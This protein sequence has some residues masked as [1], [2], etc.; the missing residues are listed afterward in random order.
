M[1]LRKNNFSSPLGLAQADVIFNIFICFVL[2]TA[3][4]VV[5]SK[6]KKEEKKDQEKITAKTRSLIDMQLIATL[7]F[8]IKWPNGP[9][10]ID[11]WVISPDNIAVGYSNT[12]SKN[13]GYLRDDTGQ[14]ESDINYEITTAQGFVA[15]SYAMNIHFYANHGV[16]SHIPVECQVLL[17]KKDKSL[18][19]IYRGTVILEFTRQE[20]TVVQF[21]LNPD[22]T[23]ADL[24]HDY[25]SIIT[26]QTSPF[27]PPSSRYN[28]DDFR[29]PWERPGP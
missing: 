22:R 20:K 10:D 19:E 27:S 6:I 11:L 15:G 28:H 26:S 9:Q 24:N 12:R 29:H 13:L 21:H 16:E 14:D 23:V 4:L 7:T 1:K 18:Y 25:R 3:L 8:T 17:Q 2:F 5:I